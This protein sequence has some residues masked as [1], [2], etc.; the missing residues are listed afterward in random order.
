MASG[1]PPTVETKPAQ[2]VQHREQGKRAQQYPLGHHQRHQ[3]AQSAFTKIL[4]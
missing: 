1:A 3:S 4:P 2:S